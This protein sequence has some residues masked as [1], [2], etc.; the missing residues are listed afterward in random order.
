MFQIMEESSGKVIG[1]KIMGKLTHEDYQEFIPFLEESIEQAGPLRL[2]C[3]TEEFTGM[4]PQAV[5][6]DMKFGLGHLRDFERMAVVGDKPWLKWCIAL[7]DRLVKT[8]VKYFEP[9][10]RAQAW[11]WLKA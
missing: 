5:W 9:A 2:L 11:A 8:E 7:G 3:E 10:Q 6:D 4:E 1:V